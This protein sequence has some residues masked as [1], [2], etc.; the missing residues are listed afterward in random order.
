LSVHN[1][2]FV[3]I[4]LLRLLLYPLILMAVI[5]FSFVV[6]NFYSDGKIDLFTYGM[7]AVLSSVASTICFVISYKFFYRRGK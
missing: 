2:M 1:K 7:W 4:E 6:L 5:F 3:R